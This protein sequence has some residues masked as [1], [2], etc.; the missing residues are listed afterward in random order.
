MHNWNHE[1]TGRLHCNADVDVVVLPNEVCVPG[2]VH[3]WDLP[4][5]LRSDSSTGESLQA[6][7]CQLLCVHMRHN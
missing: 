7:R 1:A 2:C 3:F 6:V 4:Q 5:R